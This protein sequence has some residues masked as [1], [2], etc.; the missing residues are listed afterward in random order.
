MLEE[1]AAAGRLRDGPVESLVLQARAF[2]YGLARMWIDGQFEQW[3]GAEH[4]AALMRQSLDDYV[5]RLAK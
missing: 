4:A 2:I 5:A 3:G 1:A